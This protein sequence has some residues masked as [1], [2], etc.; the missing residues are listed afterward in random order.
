MKK[1]ICAVAAALLLAGSTA[2]VPEDKG[3]SKPQPRP[4]APGKVVSIRTDVFNSQGVQQRR[5]VALTIT[6]HQAD[7]QIAT[8]I[9]K[10]GTPMRAPIHAIERTPNKYDLTLMPGVVSCSVSVAYTGQVGDILQGYLLFEGKELPGTRS[11]KRITKHDVTS[12]GTGGVVIFL[13]FTAP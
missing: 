4:P 13:Y 2:C 3:P 7:G 8:R 6:C 11:Q 9:D 5:P 12:R 1:L 10:S